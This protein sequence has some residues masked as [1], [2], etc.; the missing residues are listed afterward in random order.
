[1]T[2]NWVKNP[3]HGTVGIFDR[4]MYSGGFCVSGEVQIP[5]DVHVYY[6]YHPT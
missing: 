5:D 2:T 1:M 6:R 4:F 3:L